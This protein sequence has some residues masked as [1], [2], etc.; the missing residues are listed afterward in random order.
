MYLGSRM[1]DIDLPQD[2]IAI[3]CKHNACSKN[4]MWAVH[5]QCGLQ[6]RSSQDVDKEP[7]RNM[8]LESNDDWLQS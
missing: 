6:T 4:K 1:C 2:G 8:L 5:R 3:I 7:E